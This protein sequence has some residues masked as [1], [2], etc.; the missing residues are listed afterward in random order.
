MAARSMLFPGLLAAQH[1]AL[2]GGELRQAAQSG[3][4]L[5]DLLLASRGAERGHAGHPDPVRNDPLEL[6]VRSGLHARERQTRRRRVQARSRLGWI[7]SGSAVA[8][9]AVAL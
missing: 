2:L 9:D 6:A 4:E 5:P 3:D 7:H 1:T 8:G